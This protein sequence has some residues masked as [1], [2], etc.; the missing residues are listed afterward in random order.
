M[1]GILIGFAG[2]VFVLPALSGGSEVVPVKEKVLGAPV[3]PGWT[4]NRKDDLVDKESGAHWYQNQYFSD[5][6][7][8]KIVSFYEKQTGK[9]AFETK[10]THTW[11]ITTSEGVVINILAPP[12]GVEQRDDSNEEVIKVWKSLISI[13]KVEQPKK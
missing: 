12:E 3:Y 4:L 9:K 5:D 6:S 8:G 7:V 11:A 1:K 10:S 13:I 2:C